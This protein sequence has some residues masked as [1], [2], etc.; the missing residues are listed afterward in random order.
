MAPA[1]WASR[2]LL[3][4]RAKSRSSVVH[5]EALPGVVTVVAAWML[6]PVACTGMEIGISGFDQAAEPGIAIHLQGAPECVQMRGWMLSK[7]SGA[8]SMSCPLHLPV[9]AQLTQLWRPTRI[10][11]KRGDRLPDRPRALGNRHI[12]LSRE[13][14]AHR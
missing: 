13:D 12:F 4:Q 1:A 14:D 6:D 10:V 9:A 11:L 3:L 2:T 8:G 7:G 5:V